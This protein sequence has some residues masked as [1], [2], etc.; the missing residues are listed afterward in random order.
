MIVVLE[1]VGIVLVGV[2]PLVTKYKQR[3]CGRVE[4]SATPG[5]R[6][7][8]AVGREL[9]PLVVGEIEGVDGQSGFLTGQD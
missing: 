7:E 5:T 1:T 8:E 3:S 4:Q 6:L 9:F 2:R